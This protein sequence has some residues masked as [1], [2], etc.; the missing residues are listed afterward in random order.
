MSYARERHRS[1]CFCKLETRI[2][3][4]FIMCKFLK[5]CKKAKFC[6]WYTLF[7]NLW[8]SSV[9][10]V[11]TL[12]DNYNTFQESW[13]FQSVLIDC[14]YSSIVYAFFFFK[15]LLMCII[16]F[17]QK[18]LHLFLNQFQAGVKTRKMIKIYLAYFSFIFFFLR[19]AIHLVK[20]TGLE[21]S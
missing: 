3:W 11:Y 8:C 7:T 2:T 12:H 1:C 20:H 16:T 5:F 9:N 17:I 13:T 18:N 21:W 15:K 14:M 10:S 6:P 19:M 4:I